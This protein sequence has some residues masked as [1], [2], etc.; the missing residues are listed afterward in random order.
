MDEELENQNAAE[1]EDWADTE[2]S[3]DSMIGS[4]R[5]L[6]QD[7]I[8]SLLGFDLSDEEAAERS[9]IRARS[10]PPGRT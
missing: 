5:I 8:D 3:G 10:G 1:S 7:E 2:Q 4:E 6:N 9:G